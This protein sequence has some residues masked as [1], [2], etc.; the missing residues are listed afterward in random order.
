MQVQRLSTN[1]ADAEPVDVEATCTTADLSATDALLDS[2]DAALDPPDRGSPDQK[3]IGD[4]DYLA[5]QQWVR[6]RMGNWRPVF[7]RRNGTG[8]GLCN[9]C[10]RP[11]AGL[12]A[13]PARSARRRS[14]GITP[15]CGICTSSR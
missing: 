1:G 15:S 7:I 14:Y 13:P 4:E 11:S 3:V 10:G 6:D 12:V 2:I 5:T 9:I 8:G